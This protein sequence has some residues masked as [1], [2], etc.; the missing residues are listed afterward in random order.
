[1]LAMECD[2]FKIITDS[3]LGSKPID[4]KTFSS[5]AVLAERL[6]RLKRSN[7]IFDSVTFS[8]CVSELANRET[9]SAIS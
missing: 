5:I 4:E 9:I 8:P 7:T 6:E 1:M 2:D 3:L